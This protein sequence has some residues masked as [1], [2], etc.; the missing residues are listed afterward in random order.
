MKTMTVGDF[1]ANFSK[2]AEAVE[3][4]EEITVTY[5]KDKRILGHFVPKREEKAKKRIL[6]ALEGKMKVIFK[7]DFK[8]TEEEFL[9]L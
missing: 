7:D 2:V 1:K 8:I 3:N 9:G 5:G 4:G 6:G